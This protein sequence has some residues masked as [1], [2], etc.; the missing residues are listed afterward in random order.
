MSHRIM[1]RSDFICKR[2]E[3]NVRLTGNPEVRLDISN[4][5]KNMQRTF[6]NC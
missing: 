4:N 1:G 3:D 5:V 2:W 6:K